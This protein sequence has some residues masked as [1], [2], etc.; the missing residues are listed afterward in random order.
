MKGS[1]SKRIALKIDVVGPENIT[2]CR[3]VLSSFSLK[4]VQAGAVKRLMKHQTAFLAAAHLIAEIQVVT[5]NM[6]SGIVPRRRKNRQP[7]NCSHLKEEEE[8]VW[9]CPLQGDGAGHVR[10]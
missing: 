7:I 1:P 5:A 8:P 10:I 6:V 2:V 9:V 3:R 4:I